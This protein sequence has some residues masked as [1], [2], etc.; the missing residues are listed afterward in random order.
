DAGPTV[1]EATPFERQ[2]ADE[3]EGSR[4]SASVS[5]TK[6]LCPLVSNRNA[7]RECRCVVWSEQQFK[8]DLHLTRW[9]GGEDAAEIGREG[10]SVRDIEVHMIQE[11]EHLPAKLHPDALRELKILLDRDVD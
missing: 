6:W 10:D 4:W 5:G 1:V 7:D 9:A 2:L 11:I 8:P 3:P